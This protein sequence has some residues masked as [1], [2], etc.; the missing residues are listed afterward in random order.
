VLS[1]SVSVINQVT[2]ANPPPTRQDPLPAPP[3]SK[4]TFADLG[5]EAQTVR[6]YY[7]A[8][9]RVPLR[10]EGDALARPGGGSVRIDYAYSAQLDPRL[11]SME[12]RV[13]GLTVRSVPLDKVSG[14]AQGS[15]QVPL[16]IELLAPDATIDVVFHLF[17]RDYDQCDRVADKQIWGTVFAS[18]TIEVTRDHVVEMPDLGLLRYGNFPLTLSAPSGGTIAVLP[19]AP[20][21]RAASAGFVLSSRFG[22]LTSS[23]DPDYNLLRASDV[24]FADN[25]GK[26][27]VLLVDGGVNSLYDSMAAAGSLTLTGGPDRLLTNSGRSTLLGATVGTPYGTIEET[28][29]PA[30]PDRGVIVLRALRDDGLATL[31]EVLT[32]LGKVKLLSGNAAI[33]ADDLSVRTVDVADKRRWGS[34]PVATAAQREIQRNWWVLGALVL[35]GAFILTAIVRVWAQSRQN[36]M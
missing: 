19:D 28:F 12:V 15:V 16:P 14:E 35:G 18:S 34:L 25:A 7:P 8:S 26:H 4:F 13:S 36:R 22:R 6:G 31:V 33:V 2:E 23:A 3:A 27:F 21:G 20:D 11:S 1:G 17:P 24:G 5:I 9:V 30:S 10:L 29:S 32:D